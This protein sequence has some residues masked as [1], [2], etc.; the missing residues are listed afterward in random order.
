LKSTGRGNKNP[1]EVATEVVKYVP[2][3]NGLIEKLE[4]A[5]PGFINVFLSVDFLRHET[6]NL[7]LNDVRV[8]PLPAKK[9]VIV[10]MSSPN[11]A[12]E[13]HVGHLRSTI[14]G[15]GISRLMKF[16]GYEVD[17]VNHIGDWGTQFGMLIAHLRD[18][19]PS[20]LKSGF[21]FPV[22][23]LQAFYKESKKR[24]DEEEEFKKKAYSCVVELQALSPDIIKAW[25]M[26]CD[27]SRVEFSK[28]Y[29]RLNI[30]DL[31]ERGES[32]YQSK[33]DAVVKEL[34]EKGK[35]PKTYQCDFC[36]L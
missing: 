5:G 10:D 2:E 8:A 14:I 35:F 4:I 17:R 29:Q 6:K 34:E 16:V 36:A 9:K 18:T 20:Y 15:E 27:V 32:F 23:D 11:V 1:R 25:Q 3:D 13:M 28:I 22:R 31:I 12:K 7:F 26:I 21:R 19:F 33:M 30:S 24:F